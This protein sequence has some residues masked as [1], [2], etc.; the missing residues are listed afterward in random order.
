MSFLG[1][2]GHGFQWQLAARC[3]EDFI[4][5]ELN[6]DISLQRLNCFARDLTLRPGELEAEFQDGYF[7]SSFLILKFDEDELDLA[8]R[9]QEELLKACHLNDFPPVDEAV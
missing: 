3:L 1:P 5:E 8:K 9:T 7:K 2:E 6:I 4:E